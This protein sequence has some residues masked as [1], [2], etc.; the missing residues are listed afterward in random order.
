MY[1]RINKQVLDGVSS[2]RAKY[3][4]QASHHSNQLMTAHFVLGKM[5]IS[6]MITD[7]H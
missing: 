2:E 1:V 7:C 3:C 4:L 6:K 5:K